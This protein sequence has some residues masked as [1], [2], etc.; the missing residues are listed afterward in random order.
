MEH[1]KVLWK[2]EPLIY[3]GI[4]RIAVCFENTPELD[5]R[6]KSSGMHDGVVN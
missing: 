3:M 1:K 5:D 6:I 2:A 4:K